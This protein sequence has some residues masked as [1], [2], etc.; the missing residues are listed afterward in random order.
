MAALTNDLMKLCHANRDGSRGTQANRRDTLA[1]FAAQLGEAGYRLPSARSIKPKH[2]AAL[3][4]R[5]KG[6]GLGAGTI[7]NRMAHVRWW[8]KKVGKT[9]ILAGDNAAYGIENRV[10]SVQ[11]RAQRLDEGKA[12]KVPDAHVRASLR[13]QAA[14]GLRREEAIK[15]APRLADKGDYIALKPSWTKGGRY[16]EIPITHPRQRKILDEVKTLAGSGSLIPEGRRYVDQMKRYDYQTLKAGLSNLHGLRHG[17][18]QW[19][20]KALTGWDCPMAGGRYASAMNRDDARTD[21][22]ARLQ[23]ARELGHDRI[24]VT[25]AYLGGRRPPKGGPKS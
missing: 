9:S 7:K 25:N 17:Y 13:L 5:W 12:A 10:G 21:Y 22:A 14:F 15:F 3:V 2:I 16:R 19:R 6:E 20:Y 24:D 23:V 18:A 8:V 11:S 4:G 1:L